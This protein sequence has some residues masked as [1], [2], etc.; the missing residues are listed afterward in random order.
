MSDLRDSLEIW[1]KGNESTGSTISDYSGNSRT[2]T[3]SN[4]S[5]PAGLW[6]PGSN[7]G[8]NGNN[9][10]VTRA[11]FSP[12]SNLTVAFWFKP[13]RAWNAGTAE[14]LLDIG[15]SD[16]LQ[17]VK[18]SDNTWYAGYYAGGNDRRAIVAANSTT[19]A[20][21]TWQHII[22]TI[23]N[24]GSTLLYHNNS[25]IGTGSLSTSGSVGSNTLYVGSTRS[26]NLGFG[27]VMA[28]FRLYSRVVSS[29]ERGLLYT[30]KEPF[31][32]EY[33]P[34]TYIFLFDDKKN[35]RFKAWSA[36]G[37][38][39]SP[40][41]DGET[42]GGGGGG[43]Y[44]YGRIPPIHHVYNQITGLS[45]SVPVDSSTY[46][47]VV[48]WDGLYAG[49]GL[50]VDSGQNG[51]ASSAGS[52]GLVVQDD[53]SWALVS[54]QGGNGAMVGGEYGGGGGGGGGG[55]EYIG[56]NGNPADNTDPGAGNNYGGGGGGQGATWGVTGSSAGSAYGGGGG[57]GFS[58]DGGS[59]YE[60]ENGSTGGPG[61]TTMIWDPTLKYLLEAYWPLNESSGNA[62]DVGPN[63]LDLVDH[64]TVGYAAGSGG[65]SAGARD[66][67]SGN[68]EYFDHTDASNF[69]LG[70]GDVMFAAWVQFESLA[71]ATGYQAIIT[72]NDGGTG[73]EYSLYYD[74]TSHYITLAISTNGTSWTFL[75][76]ST[77]GTVSINTPIFIVAG[78]LASGLAFIRINN[79]PYQY[80]S[81]GTPYGSGTAPFRIGNDTS[82]NYFDGLIS[83][84]GFWKGRILSEEEQALLYGS[85]AGW[86][87]PGTP[88]VTSHG[89]SNPYLMNLTEGETFVDSITTDR[90]ALFTVIPTGIDD[91]NTALFVDAQTEIDA[92]STNLSFPSP[93][94]FSPPGD[95]DADGVYKVHVSVA[96]EYGEV[97]QDYWITILSAGGG[98]RG[99]GTLLIGVG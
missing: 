28:D 16:L 21:D 90:L 11:S 77:Y 27:G 83:R 24:G 78:R 14:Y 92:T 56:S 99:C 23:A 26:S 60:T 64:N 72:K 30:Y 81:V 66:F 17:I 63:G 75:S 41:S 12:P 53:L 94:A 61:H 57:G 40:V 36:G 18:Y 91:N 85:G 87:W 7:F 52:G 65:L 51:A 73:N 76:A 19:W 95:S 44:A 3:G 42:C 10:N 25:L 74:N 82:N 80:T 1:W 46:C 96:N 98:H 4:T 6:G 88:I 48:I 37:T 93:P 62:L 5:W 79:G 39:Y 2:G 68:S 50:I 47:S 8:F 59:G 34:G 15:T 43:G 45:L 69:H 55:T 89:G 20:I 38:G 33:T 13:F 71:G 9:T 58:Y 84:V 70:S 49:V 32:A 67:E 31:T 54:A 22:L 29:A 86:D 35:I 97:T